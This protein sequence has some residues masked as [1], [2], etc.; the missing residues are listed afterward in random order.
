MSAAGRSFEQILDPLPNQK[1]EFIWDGL[2]YLG[3]P[4][5][6]STV[7]H[8]GVGF[9]YNGVYWSA[10]GMA[11]AFGESGSSGTEIATRQEIIAWKNGELLINRPLTTDFVAQG[12]TLSNH[13]YLIPTDPSTLYKGDGAILMNDV[14]TIS[15]IA[16]NGTFAYSGDG[17]PATQA[18]L[19]QP[20]GMAFDIL[21]NLY[22]ADTYNH[23]VRKVDTGGIITTVAGN[24]SASYSGDGGPATQ[25]ALAM[26]AGL[27]FDIM[28]N[29][30][31]T[32][33]SNERIRKVDASGIITTVAGNGQCSPVHIGD[34]G[35]ATQ[36]PLCSPRD[37]TIDAFGN[38]YIAEFGTLRI[39]K[40]DTNGVI[41]TVA[42]NGYPGLSGDGGP[43]TQATF[44]H[45]VG[46]ATDNAGNLYIADESNARV[47]KVDVSGII[48][49]VAGSG[50][51][52]SGG[53]S[54]DGGPA[55]QATMGVG[56]EDVALDSTGNLYIADFWNSRIR[57]VDTSGIITTFAGNGTWGYAGDGG[58]AT[59]A[60]L[61]LP[62]GVAVDVLGNLYIADLYN[63]R[64]RK[65]ALYSAPQFSPEY[66]GFFFTEEGGRGYILSSAGRHESTIDLD[67]RLTLYTFGY[68][69]NNNLISISDQFGNVTTIQRN[70]SGVP[71][72]IIS[73]GGLTTTLTIDGNNNLTRITY[74]DTSFY[75][76]EYTPDGLMTAKIEPEGN[77]LEHVFD[78]VGRVTDVTD[79]EGGHW[80]YSRT[81]YPNGN[82]ETQV[83]SA[84]GNLTT[85]LDNT[86]STGAY[87]S[88]ITDP[89]GSETV[90]TRSAD[91]LTATKSLSCGMNLSYKYDVDSQNKF[92]FL[93]EITEKT[94][95]GLERITLWGKT[96]QDT[97]A[98]NTID[99]ITEKLTLN[100]KLATLVTDTLQS[101]R[102]LTSPG[103]RS[104]TAFYDPNNLLTTR[105]TIPGVYDTTFGYDTK[106]RVTSIDTDIR[107]ATFAYDTQGNLS[108]FTDPENRTTTYSYDAVGRVTGILRPDSSTIS[109]TYD[110][111]GNMTVLT[112][113]S[114]I[115][116]G[117]GYNKVNL[118]SSYQ[119]PL[120]GSYSYLYN[121]DRQLKQV[122]FPSGKQ[123]GLLYEHE[124]LSN[125]QTP[126]GNIDIS[127]LCSSKVGSITKGTEVITYGYDGS[128]ITSETL[129][130]TLNQSLSY[131]YN[132]D[133]N[134]RQFTYAGG[135][136][137]FTY[138]NDGLLTE[139]GPFTITRN[140]ANGLPESVTDGALNLT[141]SF[142]GHG[143]LDNQ[144]FAV[145][146][147][148]LTS[149]NL[150][151]D[152]AGRIIAKA[153]TVGGITS[154]YVY[155]YDV[156]GRLLTVTKDST[157]VEE[158]QY[159]PI[160]R[161]TYEMNAQK[162]ISGRTYTYS[163]EDHLITT[164]DT[165]FQYDAD[166]FLTT[167]TRGSDITR[168]NYSSRGELLNVALP[169]G[170][171]IEYINDPLGRRI[172]KK[173]NGTIIEK[174]L[175]QGLTRLLAV[176]DGSNNLIM[177]FNYADGRMPVAM[178]EGGTTYY[179][180]Y[181]QVGS[182]R[183]IA[184]ASGNV[185]KRIDYDSSGSVI[186]DTNPGF[187]VTFGFVGGL[188]DKDTGLLRFGLR[189]YDPEV[190]RWTAKDPIGFQGG[191]TDLY[192]YVGGNPV[193]RIDPEGL[194][195]WFVQ[196][197]GAA[198]I[199][200]P[201]F[202][203]KGW[204]SQVYFGL[205]YDTTTQRFILYKSS[206]ATG[207]SS[208]DTV[209]GLGFGPG[210][211]GGWVKDNMNDFLGK[212]EEETYV[213]AVSYS[214]TVTCSGRP[215]RS[216]GIGKGI[217]VGY[218]DVTTNTRVILD[219]NEL[220]NKYDKW[221]N[222]TSA[223]IN[224][225]LDKVLTPR[226]Y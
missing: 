143:E 164:G 47:R 188:D 137:N 88:H 124:R 127:Y 71:T 208:V 90:Y 141:R 128:L 170:T 205:A 156:M 119:T 113:P 165:T 197:G 166:G 85:Y 51:Q 215:G 145:N 221:L 190:G 18:A 162:G 93:K 5:T 116:H 72:A 216:F 70:A 105:L 2:D 207:P 27:A 75:T 167:K 58:P 28:G 153:E 174:Y 14:N 213:A 115:N 140:A 225:W 131:I 31:I 3:R 102:I 37:V 217:A 9:V 25:A 87:T 77:R 191:D 111:N 63:S 169:D 134:L 81:T 133:F 54:G 123:I 180:T 53:Y 142:S 80:Q 106:G 44:W 112:N 114:A 38:L 73:S 157:L 66:S 211:T 11:W 185:I 220:S 218:T 125:V 50:P 39:R 34:G 13:H 76:F 35:P 82:I 59:E 86:D 65:M 152:N 132:N 200:D 178:T 68:D 195:V 179:L 60:G 23:R 26:P 91:G 168:Y 224:N 172:A 4:A 99:L 20:I 24:G 129:G 55:I 108:T 78:S 175:W 193:N 158:Y 8:V 126:E 56:V 89:S 12:W 120:S 181:D 214:K 151:R 79:Q 210:A 30:Y 57:K 135:S 46:I 64:I 42:G 149:W 69:Q 45:P 118:N 61:Y 94:S 204:L 107:R 33:S 201:L 139:A 212:S 223:K 98:D 7:V 183:I 29:L 173:V 92:K 189:D 146:G 155:T 95:S 160:G 150:S 104:I 10:G 198:F 62:M 103:G 121:R 209:M 163:E 154:N 110:K 100:S 48:T 219:F 161:R 40:V 130:G 203:R 199:G 97:N 171:A 16:G 182:L 19:A 148:S 84:E 122:S 206:A 43:A 6:G 136:V 109:F 1:V 176:Y 196:V 17:G 194:D 32:D 177:R 67:T 222:E 83:L 117:F 74:P 36:A 202:S 138:D 22:I 52:G 159:D 49:T 192:G 186:N 41:T 21:G 187:Q 96:Y 147:L 226:W 101:K 184:D 15:T 144:N